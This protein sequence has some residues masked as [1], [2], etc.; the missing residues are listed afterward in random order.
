MMGSLNHGACKVAINFVAGRGVKIEIVGVD[1][2]GGSNFGSGSSG[3]IVS[4]SGSSGR[5]NG[6]SG[7]GGGSGSGSR[8]SGI[9][10]SGSGCSSR[11]NG[12]SD[13]GIANRHCEQ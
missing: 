5:N 2:G 7:G 10:D 1:G 9:I 8:S 11:N 4:G 3:I 6:I 13:G 12:I